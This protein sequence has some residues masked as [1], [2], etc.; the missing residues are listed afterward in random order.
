VV[1]APDGR[2]AHAST[3]YLFE[4]LAR[5]IE[6][7][8]LRRPVVLDIRGFASTKPFVCPGMTQSELDM[9]NLDLAETRRKS[10][11][12]ELRSRIDSTK[13]Q[14]NLVIVFEGD[15][16]WGTGKSALEAMRKGNAFEDRDGTLTQ[17]S[18][19]RLSRYTEIEILSSGD[20][21]RTDA[22][23]IASKG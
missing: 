11:I 19:E 17:E 20:C 18:R 4:N 12:T 2:K 1:D 5:G 3:E 13:Y 22:T 6:A 7:C 14:R 16:R 15:P 23:V 10:I 21:A 9:L 8:G